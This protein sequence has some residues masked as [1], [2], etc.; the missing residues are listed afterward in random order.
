MLHLNQPMERLFVLQPR[1]RH[2]AD[3]CHDCRRDAG[4]DRDDLIGFRV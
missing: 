1:Q 2:A 4:A 3:Q